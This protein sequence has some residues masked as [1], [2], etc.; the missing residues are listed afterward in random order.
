LAAGFAQSAA[1]CYTG[2]MSITY[3]GID[4]LGV[5]VSD[6]EAATD[7]YG[8]LLGMPITGGEEIPERGIEVRFVDT[9][10][11]RIELLAP[12]R[13]DSE[14]SRFLGKRGEGL[15]HICL[16]VEDLEATLKQMKTNGVRL[17]DE[18]P[19]QGSGGSRVAFVHPK[20]THGVLLELVEIAKLSHGED[21]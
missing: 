6:L 8:E 21:A 19:R 5:V 7:T 2:A 20:A 12:M 3:K 15:H 13:G 14:I 16:E 17:I 10:N 18:I 1:L 4:H 11:S 9:G